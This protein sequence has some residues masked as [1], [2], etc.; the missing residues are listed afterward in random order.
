MEG[1]DLGAL[2]HN[3]ADYLHLV[4]EA[5][6]LAFADRSAYL[7]DRGAMPEGALATLIAKEYATR[8]RVEI[9]PRRASTFKPGLSADRGTP[10]ELAG[11]DRGDTVYLTVADGQGNVVSFIQ[12]LFNAFGAGIVA[13]DTGIALHNRGSGFVLTP[14]HPNRIG[15]H[16][17]PLHTL[18]PAMI[19][20]DGRPWASLGVMGG[21]NQAQAHAQVVANLVD[22]GMGIQQ[23]GEAARMR[24]QGATLALESGIGADVRTALEARGHVVVDGRGAMGGFQGIRFDQATGVMMGGS[25]PRKDGMAIGW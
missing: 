12:S 17:R 1:F 7:A 8:R 15:P 22:F 24:H 11:R 18:V 6:K 25:D 2:G 9:D 4:S 21:D 3:S 5:K 19:L 10:F 20:K 16:K 14:G 23:A 13:G